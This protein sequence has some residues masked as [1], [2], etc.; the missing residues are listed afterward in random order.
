LDRNIVAP[1]IE[2]QVNPFSPMEPGMFKLSEKPSGTEDVAKAI[3]RLQESDEA[4]EL[5]Q[6]DNHESF[7]QFRTTLTQA[8]ATIILDYITLGEF[9][10]IVRASGELADRWHELFMNVSD[11]KLPAVHNLILLLAHVLMSENQ[12]KARELFLRVRD[13]EP[14]MKLTYGKAGIQLD[15]IATWAGTSSPVFDELRFER[16]DR[17]VNDHELFVEVLAALLNGK[18]EI[19]DAYIESKFRRKEPSEIARGIMVAGLS[20]SSEFN[21]EALKRFEG[22]AGLVGDAL[23]AAKYAYNRNVWARHWYDRMCRT[24]DNS[25]FWCCSVLF[26][27]IV[28]AR[29]EFWGSTFQQKGASAQLFGPSVEDALRNRYRRWENNRK[30]KLFG[31]DA[32]TPI[33][34]RS[35]F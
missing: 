10:A 32:P 3:E 31:A 30:K 26:L 9:A 27:R 23:K 5:R 18:K 1:E 17:A 28:D 15:Q 4:F 29:F 33:F 6:K 2:F 34:I 24:D 12:Q 8:N 35:G 22:G 14:L 13:N 25:E 16:L 11:S 21:D 7:L 19:L 20:D